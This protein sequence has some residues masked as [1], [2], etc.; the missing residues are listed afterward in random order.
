MRQKVNLISE[1]VSWN[2]TLCFSSSSVDQLWPNC[3]CI[4][5][6]L[7]TCGS[8]ERPFPPPS[9]LS[10]GNSNFCRIFLIAHAHVVVCFFV[11]FF[12]ALH[13]RRTLIMHLFIG[14]NSNKQINWM[15]QFCL[16]GNVEIPREHQPRVF[17][18]LYGLFC[19]QKTSKK[20]AENGK[21]RLWNVL[22]VGKIFRLHNQT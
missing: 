20:S 6:M 22:E 8:D 3:N 9:H 21:A 12:F 19:G 17:P 13:F 1:S 15:A 14:H 10:P 5:K 16:C 4:M 2:I 18:Q 7:C 11:F